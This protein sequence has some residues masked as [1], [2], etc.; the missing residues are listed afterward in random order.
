MKRMMRLL[1]IT[2]CLVLGAAAMAAVP[3]TA[4]C[5]DGDRDVPELDQYGLKILSLWVS[6][7]DATLFWLPNGA[8]A[9][10]DTGQHFAVKEYLLPFLEQHGIER[11]DYLILTHY[12]GD[13]IAGMVEENGQKYVGYFYDKSI[14]RIPVGTFWDKKSFKS[15]EQ[16]NFGGTN[17]K[18]LNSY[19]GNEHLGENNQSLAFL[20][21]YKGFRYGLGGDIYA[22]EQEKILRN[23]PDDV[24]VHA[25]NTNH[26]MHGSVSSEFLRR[27][28]PYLFITSAE[29][30]VYERDAYTKDL[31]GVVKELKLREARL[32]ESLLTLENGNILLWANSGKDW[33]YVCQKTGVAFSGLKQDIVGKGK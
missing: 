21:E 9:L 11:I 19:Y 3:E 23:F 30:A 29:Q 12:H 25:Y 5:T 6:H 2:G 13:H 24:R 17:L 26:H 18:I 16:V 28:D 33:S 31:M 7:G 8:I 15:G 27:S 20:L 4:R 14:K 10:V 32:L 22:S 1:C